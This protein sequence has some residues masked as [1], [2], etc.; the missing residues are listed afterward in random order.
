MLS[1]LK[2][3][4]FKRDSKKILKGIKRELSEVNEELI[5]INKDIEEV[6]IEIKELNDLLKKIKDL[7]NNEELELDDEEIENYNNYKEDLY[8][9]NL[10]KEDLKDNEY[11]VLNSALLLIRN[12]NGLNEFMETKDMNIINTLGKRDFGEFYLEENKA[13]IYNQL[14]LILN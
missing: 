3:M 8:V 1:F 6:E 14:K 9:L 5:A 13:E 12:F 2:M 7:I 11:K 4:C 10:I